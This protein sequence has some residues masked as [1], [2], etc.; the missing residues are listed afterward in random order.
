MKNLEK[1]KKTEL[2]EEI[3]HL[4][5]QILCLEGQTHALEDRLLREFILSSA[6]ILEEKNPTI[7]P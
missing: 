5:R 2:I 6:T 3:M 7:V 1:W 4:R